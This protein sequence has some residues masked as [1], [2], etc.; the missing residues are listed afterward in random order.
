MKKT[1]KKTSLMTT[2]TESSRKQTA[3]E[4]TSDV[5]LDEIQ[6]AEYL[7]GLPSKVLFQRKL[8]EAVRFAR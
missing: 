2:K 7:T 5:L 8:N 3:L 1:Q 6:V 4:K